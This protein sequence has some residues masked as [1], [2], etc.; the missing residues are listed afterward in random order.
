VTAGDTQSCGET[1]TNRG[2]CWG[3]NA[4][5]ELGDGSKTRSL[6]PVAVAGGLYFAQLSAGYLH[7][8][9]RTPDAVGYCW[10]YGFFAQLGDGT[11]SFGAEAARPVPVAGPR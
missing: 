3:M 10:G 8:C 7:T 1:T 9:G 6:K 5:G 2:Y 4:F 11:S